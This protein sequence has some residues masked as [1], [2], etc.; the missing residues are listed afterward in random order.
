MSPEDVEI[1]RA[2]LESWLAQLAA[3]MNPE[4]TISTLAEIWDPRI[5]LD[6]TDADALDLSGVYRGPEEARQFW[7]E[8]LSAWETI[9]FDPRAVRLP[10][11]VLHEPRT[12]DAGTPD[13]AGPHATA[14]ISPT[15]S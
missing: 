5:E 9:R 12:V 4:E 15:N 7:L 10:D 14:P 6:A 2:N 8:W 1:W 11:E 13:H 3:G